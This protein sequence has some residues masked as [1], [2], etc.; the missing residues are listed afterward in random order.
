MEEEQKEKKRK[1]EGVDESLEDLPSN[2]LRW[3][4]RKHLVQ[5]DHLPLRIVIHFQTENRVVDVV[6]EKSGHTV[7]R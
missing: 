7:L 3:D 4:E 5:S 1:E 2:R 6:V